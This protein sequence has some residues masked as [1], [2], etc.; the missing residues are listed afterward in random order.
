MVWEVTLSERLEGVYYRDHAG[1]EQARLEAKPE[2]LVLTTHA[3]GHTKAP[4]SERQK[5]GEECQP[6]K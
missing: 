4:S 3:T 6:R 1:T 5:H 2:A